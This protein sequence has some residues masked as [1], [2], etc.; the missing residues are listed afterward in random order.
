MFHAR[1][2][3]HILNLCVQDGLDPTEEIVDKVRDGVKYIA[4]S[5]GRRI[6]FAEI[7]KSLGLKCKKLILDVSTCWNSTYNMLA[8]AIEFKNVFLIYI[9]SDQGFKVYVPSEED[10]ERVAG[11]CFFLE[12][13]S[14]VTKVV[15]GTGYSTS[16]LFL[17]KIRRVK[18][19]IDKKAIDPNLHI[20]EMARKMELKFE[21]YL[22]ETNLVMC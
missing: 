1:C 3:A 10:W 14:D 13:F 15:S 20:R 4:A 5:E 12:V 21:K 2:C 8:C 11:V 16:N 19:I 6:K 9:T 7:S 22:G 17:S 18:K